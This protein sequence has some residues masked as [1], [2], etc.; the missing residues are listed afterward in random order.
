MLEIRKIISFNILILFFLITKTYGDNLEN[1]FNELKKAENIIEAENIE[2]KIWESWKTHPKS[3]YLT[4]KLENATYSMNHQ[5]YH[6]ALKL[7]TDIINEDPNWA[8]GWNKRATLL[9]IMGN[10]KQ[11][12][13]DIEKVLKIEPRHFGALSGRAQIYLSYSQFEKAI[14]DLENARVI[15]PLIKSGDT[16][17]KIKKIIKELQI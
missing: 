15:Y 1:L 17:E 11:S 13:K 5:Q 8:E 6:I 9:F 2:E 3:Q 14:K 10:Y 16:I 12:L 7:F 4:N